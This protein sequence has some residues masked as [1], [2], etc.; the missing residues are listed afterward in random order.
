MSPAVRALLE[1]VEE[2][3]VGHGDLPRGQ[4]AQLRGLCAAVRDEDPLALKF[5]QAVRQFR[6]REEQAGQ[7]G[8]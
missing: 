5:K 3:A 7:Y 1:A 8:Q 4:A 2:L 6:A